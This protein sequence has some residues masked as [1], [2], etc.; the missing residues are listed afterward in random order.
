M[1]RCQPI[2]N[3]HP[4]RPNLWWPS[5][6]GLAG[7]LAIAACGALAPLLPLSTPWA[8]TASDQDLRCL[9]LTLYWEAREDGRPGMLAVGWVVLNRRDRAKSPPTICEVVREGKR[10]TALPILVLVRWQARRAHGRGK[11]E[12]GERGGHRA[13]I[14]AAARSGARRHLLSPRWHPARLVDEASSHS[15]GGSTLLLSLNRDSQES[16]HGHPLPVQVTPILGGTSMSARPVS[17]SVFRR[18]CRGDSVR[19]SS[20]VGQT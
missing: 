20:R 15:S 16:S 11:L 3:T 10:D 1:H 9:A 12:T 8:A 14:G 6:A 18:R 2:V 7:F 17:R 13:S 5:L 19:I 4:S